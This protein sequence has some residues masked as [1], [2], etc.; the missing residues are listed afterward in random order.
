V[1]GVIGRRLIVSTL[2]IRPRPLVHGWLHL[3][4]GQSLVLHLRDQLEP[5][6]LGIPGSW[7]LFSG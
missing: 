3:Q 5:C 1:C 6:D 4:H 7:V 2:L